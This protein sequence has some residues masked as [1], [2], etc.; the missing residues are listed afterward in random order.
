ML[1]RAQPRDSGWHLHK[2]DA[3]L[4]ARTMVCCVY[5]ALQDAAQVLVDASDQHGFQMDE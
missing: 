2:G 1:E 4:S 3:I 5:A